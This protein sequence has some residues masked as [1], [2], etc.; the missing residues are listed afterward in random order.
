MLKHTDDLT[1][2]LKLALRAILKNSLLFVI[3]LLL[4]LGFYYHPYFYQLG[5]F[6]LLVVGGTVTFIIIKLG[7]WINST[8]VIQ[9]YDGVMLFEPHQSELIKN[10]LM[11]QTIRLPRASRIRKGHIIRAKL[12]LESD[13]YFA[14]LLITDVRKKAID[15][16]TEEDVYLSGYKNLAEFKKQWEEKHGKINEDDKVRIIKFRL[17]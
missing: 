13:I 3:S 6:W 17:I 1:I 9:M 11:K 14:E 15:Q 7:A 10:G 5:L 16:L 12:S 2:D 8:G 4:V